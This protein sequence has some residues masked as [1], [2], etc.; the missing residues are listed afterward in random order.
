MTVAD[1]GKLALVVEART[2]SDRVKAL[3]IVDGESSRQA[4]YLLRSIKGVRADIAKWFAPHIEAAQATKRAA[5]EARKALVDESDRI[6]APLAEAEIKIKAALLLWE[7]DEDAR[8]RELEARLQAEAQRVAEAATLDAAADLE[9]QAATELD[10]D[11]ADALLAEAEAIVSQPVE[12]PAVFVPSSVPKV[13]GIVYRDRWIAHPDIDVQALAA[14]VAAGTA[15]ATF[16]IPNRAAINAWVR[17]TQGHPAIPGIR[18]INDRQI[19]A[20]G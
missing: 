18:V 6:Q 7:R 20:R 11:V 2:W 16:L 19:A 5:D 14:A 4:A 17:A 10:A 3:A 13:Q 15:P 9:R 1:G 12:A 8:R